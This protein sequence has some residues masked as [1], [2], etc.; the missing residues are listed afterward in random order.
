MRSAEYRLDLVLERPGVEW[1][2]DTGVDARLRRRDHVVGP[3]FRRNHDERRLRQG[4]VA[5]TA[6]K[7][8][9]TRHGRGVPVADDKAVFLV[10]HFSD[11]GRPV[12]GGVDIVEPDLFQ[13]VAKNADRRAVVVD[14]EHRHRQ[15]DGH[16]RAPLRAA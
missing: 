11:G 7:Q 10:A 16:V 2:E 3:G 4:G 1:L 12:G 8:F 15:V 13:Q 9:V 5:A 6:L 14:D